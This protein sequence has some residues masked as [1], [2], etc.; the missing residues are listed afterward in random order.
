MKRSLWLPL[1]CCC[2]AA[3]LCWNGSRFIGAKAKI[4]MKDLTFLPSPQTARLLTLGHN[5]TVAKLRWIDSFAYFQMQLERK[6]D[7]VA[8]T[9]DSAFGRLYDTLIALDPHFIPLYEHALLN[10]A[11]LLS[12]HQAILS[13]LQRGLIDNPHSTVLWRLNLVEFAT[14]YD[15][16]NRNPA[17]QA[18]TMGLGRR[19]GPP[20]KW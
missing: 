2:T 6:D 17:R 11:G 9:G 16:E 10:L 20:Q 19:N 8:S 5:N 12:H 14:T 4:R 13:L 18:T 7:T 1:A 15:A 3:L